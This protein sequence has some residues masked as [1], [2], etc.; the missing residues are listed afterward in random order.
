MFWRIWKLCLTYIME[1]NGIE[2][3]LPNDIPKTITMDSNKWIRKMNAHYFLIDSMAFFDFQ[4]ILFG[5]QNQWFGLIENEISFFS[6]HFDCHIATIVSDKGK[7]DWNVH[8]IQ[9][10]QI[11]DVFV[12]LLIIWINIIVFRIDCML[13]HCTWH[14]YLST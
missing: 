14:I 4:E 1:S 3:L 6:W 9:D 13:L 8:N 2:K 11:R 7:T 5:Y 10:N 12:L